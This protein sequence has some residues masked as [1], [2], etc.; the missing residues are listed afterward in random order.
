MPE[1]LSIADLKKKYAADPTSL[2]VAE[3]QQLRKVQAIAQA[4]K[5]S[6]PTYM[7]HR[8][9]EVASFFGCSIET[10]DRWFAKGAPAEARSLYDL[11]KIAKWHF[12][13]KAERDGADST[14]VT[15]EKLAFLKERRL[16][17]RQDRLAKAARLVDAEEVRG[18]V[19]TM[20]ADVRSALL[21][22]PAQ[23]APR[24]TGKGE[25]EIIQVLDADIRS[26]LTSIAD[27]WE[28]SHE[29]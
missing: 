2:T 14:A 18:Q 13:R 17:A 8:R 9:A 10:V 22:I 11:A 28:Q 19:M 27:S 20:W 24:L 3:L 15:K 1:H 6:E 4:Q 26:A 5:Q 29:S 23:A 21:V 7:V 12:G 16:G 25:A